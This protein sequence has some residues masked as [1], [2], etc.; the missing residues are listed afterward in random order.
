MGNETIRLDMGGVCN[1]VA[2]SG[3]PHQPIVRAQSSPL[4]LRPKALRWAFP[5][6]DSCP[7][8]QWRHPTDSPLNFHKEIPI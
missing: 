8:L 6:R 1:Q 7:T 5:W 2:R 4:V 3:S